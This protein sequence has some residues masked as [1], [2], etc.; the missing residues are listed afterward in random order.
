[1][2]AP[3]TFSPAPDFVRNTGIMQAHNG[4]TYDE[5]NPEG[6]IMQMVRDGAGGT[7]SGDGLKQCLAR[8]GGDYYEALRA[9][10]SGTVDRGDLSNGI[11]ATPDYVSKMANRLL[12]RVWENM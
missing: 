4:A 9:Y 7:S 10:N 8:C 1:M 12:G 2:R 11:T 3:I 5:R 6:S